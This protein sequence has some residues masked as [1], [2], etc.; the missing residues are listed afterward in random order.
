[1]LNA[2]T[3]MRKP[4]TGSRLFIIGL[5]LCCVSDGTALAEPPSAP[6]AVVLTNAAQV[7][8]LDQTEA[9]QRLPVRLKGVVIGESD[10]E[11]T[12]FALQDATGGVYLKAAAATVAALHPGD[13]VEVEGVSD[14]GDF[15]PFVMAG[16]VCKTGTAELPEP[17]RVT[18]EE[19]AS[20]KLDAQWVEVSGIVRTCGPSVGDARKCRIDLDTGGHRLIVRWMMPNMNAS[21]VDAEVRMRGVCYYLVNRNRQFLSP[22]LAIP[23][24]VPVVIEVPPP[25]DPFAAPVLPV[26]SLLHFAPEGSYGHRVHVR[27]V[28]IRQQPGEWRFWIRDGECAVVAQTSQTGELNPGDEV[29]V[30]GFPE[31]GEYS[32]LLADAVFRSSPSSSPPPAPLQ[33]SDAPAA[34]DHDADL[35]ELEATLNGREIVD[36]GWSFTLD[37]GDGTEFKALL[38]LPP[39]QPA[40]ANSLPGSLVRVA[41]VC[42]VFRDYNGL[43]SGLSHP[44]AFQLLLR[45]AADLSVIQPPPWWTRQRITWL[46]SAIA[47]GSLLAVAGVLVAARLRLREQAA[48]RARA[49]AEFSAILGERNRLAREIHDIL[50][51]G[52]SAIVLHLDLAR[53]EFPQDSQRTAQH[54]NIAHGLARSSMA[55]ASNAVWNLRSQVLETNDLPS[56][57]K[58]ILKQLTDGTSVNARFELT[59][60]PR[61]LPPATENAILRIGQEAITNAIKHAR[62]KHIEVGLDFAAKSVKLRV[63]DDG[64]GFDLDQPLARA[65]GFGLVGIRERAAQL[66]GELKILSRQEQ[67]T[68]ISLSV[69]VAS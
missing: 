7:H 41:G 5:S 38:R 56:A 55:D 13:V 24:D 32:P 57:L 33:L 18:F 64:C 16:K 21:L 67:G 27:G 45:S 50:A 39:G 15:A 69:P 11:D 10:P 30:L 37:S 54:L 9:A 34:F 51:Q 22:L 36:G 12:G 66:G 48:N 28:V 29:D 3:M 8:C 31:Q 53:D 43:Q 68:E 2:A 61:R 52:L 49:E 20:G 46:L 6:D 62:A 14:P 63:K 25:P 60:Q 65:G 23:H 44:A 40:P 35:V 17:K 1:M 59:G 47:G 58:C 4:C 26:S 19:L 42:S